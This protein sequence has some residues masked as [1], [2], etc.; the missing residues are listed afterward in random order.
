MQRPRSFE[1]PCGLN[2]T[3]FTLL[4]GQLES[5]WT[6]AH[7]TSLLWKGRRRRIG[8]GGP[9]KLDVSHRLLLTLIYLRHSLPLHLLGVL[10]EL[11]AT[12]VCRN[13]HALLP[14]LEQAVPAPFRARTMDSRKVTPDDAPRRRLRTLEDV[15]EAFPEI[16]DIIV[17][18]TEQP[19]GQPKKKKGGGPGK[20][21]VGR[22]KDQKK[23]FSKKG[24][25]TLN[26]Q[27]AVT[28][29][30]LVVHLSAPAGGR[31]HDMKVLKQSRLLR[32]LPRGSRV[33]G[34]RG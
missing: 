15:L 33:W 14:L 24:T 8:A 32:R 19:R 20:N 7:R 27:V 29:D 34:D 10:F 5:L 23:F 26:T 22:P 16:A 31:T 13:I 3:E 30:G 25:H 2:P 17:D 9:F 4:A 1:S 18:G 21:A 11:D 12:N 6:W 28:P